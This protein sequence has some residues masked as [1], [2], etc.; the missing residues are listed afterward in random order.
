MNA[1]TAY[2]DANSVIG[3][4]GNRLSVAD[5]PQSGTP[6]WVIRRK[7]EIVAAVE[8]GLISLEDACGRYM[9]TVEEF[10]AWQY[11]LGNDGIKGLSDRHCR[12]RA[13]WMRL[14]SSGDAVG[15]TSC[16]DH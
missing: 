2:V 15:G 12:K 5:L 11:S 6:R 4:H 1:D 10:L 16:P 13:L 8:G 14:H 9:L 7:A 3:P